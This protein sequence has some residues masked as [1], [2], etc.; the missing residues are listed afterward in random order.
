MRS[1]CTGHS[2]QCGPGLGGNE[3]LKTLSSNRGSLIQNAVSLVSCLASH[4]GNP[5]ASMHGGGRCVPAVVVHPSL[6]LP[7]GL[8]KCNTAS[9]AITHRWTAARCLS[10]RFTV[11]SAPG[12]HP[13]LSPAVS[14]SPLSRPWM[15]RRWLACCRCGG[16]VPFSR[17]PLGALS[18]HPHYVMTT[19]KC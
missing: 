14:H 13:A 6:R 10:A 18:R 11:G 16:G 5:A 8:I 12:G 15:M 9:S 7:S 4:I 17:G 19:N 3:Q 2:W 1:G